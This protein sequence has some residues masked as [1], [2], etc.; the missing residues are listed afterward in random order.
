MINYHSLF[1]HITF[2]IVSIATERILTFI[3]NNHNNHYEITT[4]SFG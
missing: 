3:G 2:T 4:T 1:R